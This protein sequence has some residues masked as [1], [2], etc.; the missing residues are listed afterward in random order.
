VPA[1]ADLGHVHFIAIGGSGMSAVARVMLGRGV[2]V[3]GSDAKDGPVLE[4]LRS[5]GA[6]VVVGH[7][8]AHVAGAGTVV[9]SSAIPE[10]N[11]ELAAARAAGLRVLHRSQGIAAAMGES[12]RAAVAGA[13][14]KTTTTSMLT[15][16]L[17]AAGLDP[18]F[19]SGGELTGQGTNAA[20]TGSPVFVVEADESDGSFLVYRPEVAI[21]TNVQ[22]DHL[23]FYGTFAEV[24]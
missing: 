16:A 5:L 6:R 20:W 14:G 11:V 7:D 3:S 12:R 2:S 18:S 15:V 8:P 19:A 13:N 10:G 23:D 17:Q 24:E 1:L 4:E 22:P 21:V 9:I